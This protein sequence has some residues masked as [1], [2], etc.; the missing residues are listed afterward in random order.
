MELPLTA[1]A[2]NVVFAN[3]P[4]CFHITL[5]RAAG[6]VTGAWPVW[7]NGAQEWK[8]RGKKS[9]LK[10]DCFT[11]DFTHKSS[12]KDKV[13]S[14]YFYIQI[15]FQSRTLIT[16][17][18]T[19]YC[20]H[21]LKLLKT[22]S[23]LSTTPGHLHGGPEAHRPSL[24]GKCPHCYYHCPVK[25]PDQSLILKTFTCTLPP[26]G[27]G[28]RAGNGHTCRPSPPAY[29]CI[30]RNCHTV[31]WENLECNEFMFNSTSGERGK[32]NPRQ[33]KHKQMLKAM[34]DDQCVISGRSEKIRTKFQT[35]TLCKS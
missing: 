28:I 11:V 9:F 25:I 2:F 16:T 19:E 15:W 4:S 24:L 12:P 21:S 5:V 31:C 26:W 17:E 32:Q 10:A 35:R 20:A 6:R 14:C 18:E 23:G 33:K 22:L 7:W 27:N 29:S 1:E 13:N 8:E 3:T 34:P 30:C